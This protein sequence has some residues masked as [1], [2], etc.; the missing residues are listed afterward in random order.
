MTV[1]DL[2][3]RYGELRFALRDDIH[4]L[5]EGLGFPV[6]D[7]HDTILNR[8]SL[9]ELRWFILGAEVWFANPMLREVL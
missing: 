8:I 5:A 2:H 9:E 7:D 4:R 3:K 1:E 6:D